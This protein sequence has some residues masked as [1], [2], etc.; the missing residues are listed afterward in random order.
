VRADGARLRQIQ[1]FE[2][3]AKFKAL[4]SIK[5]KFIAV[6][7]IAIVAAASL[8]ANS[9]WANSKVASAVHEAELDVQKLELVVAMEKANLEMVLMAMDSIIDKDEGFIQPE[10]VEIIAESVETLRTS[11]ARLLE[12]AS[13]TEERQTITSIIEA[14]EP[15]AQGIQVD[16]AALIERNAPQEAFTAIDD[17]I[18]EFGESMTVSLDA[19]EHEFSELTH[20]ANAKVQDAASASDIANAAVFGV[21][22]VI[23]GALSFVFGRMIVSQIATMSSAMREL[24]DGNNETEVPYLDQKA[25]MGQMAQA[26]EVFKQNALMRAKLEAEQVKKREADEKR[27]REVEALIGEFDGTAKRSLSGVNASAEQMKSSATSMTS[28]S[29]ETSQRSSS[30]AAAAEQA[31]ANVQTVATATEELSASVAE[32]SRQV[33]QSA[34]MAK[35]AVD[36]ATAT[37]AKVEGLVEAAE[38]IGEVVNLIND[39]AAQTNLLALNATIEAS[40]AGEAGKGFAVVASEVKSL[41]SQ[42]AKATEDIGA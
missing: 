28:I 14:I 16:L 41:A 20:K 19:L 37:N 26:V 10:R 29:D 9:W 2:M 32:I 15:L 8:A 7:A 17:V 18:D 40:R 11:S 33:A 24:A 30:V 25:E 27:A 4:E 31:T 34:D 3:F 23:L 36:S 39:I 22:V 38:Q 42:T 12:L 35:N 5:A 6:T 13:S 21:A 1:G